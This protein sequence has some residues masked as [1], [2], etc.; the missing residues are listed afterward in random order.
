MAV[1]E[2]GERDTIAKT[3]NQRHALP[4]KRTLLFSPKKVKFRAGGTLSRH[5]TET[6]LRPLHLWLSWI[7]RRDVNPTVVSFCFFARPFR[8][9]IRKSTLLGDG[10]GIHILV[11]LGTKRD[12]IF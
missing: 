12:L 1:G 7:P 10:D 3:L 8:K 11:D 4:Y 9:Y 2:E 6:R 5:C